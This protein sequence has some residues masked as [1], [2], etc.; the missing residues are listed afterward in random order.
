MKKLITSLCAFALTFSVANAQDYTPKAG[1]WS[2]ST[3]ASS[4]LTYV[5]NLFNGTA[6]APT[7]DFTNE[8]TEDKYA[9][10][11]KM[12]IDDNTAWRGQLNIGMTSSNP[13]TTDAASSSFD[14]VLGLGKE[15]RRGGDRLQGYYG[16]QAMMMLNSASEDD[17]NGDEISS[18][19]MFGFG[20][21]GFIGVEYF[22]KPKMSLGAEYTHGLSF[23]SGDDAS[24]FDISGAS[25]AIRMNFYF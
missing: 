18:E 9:V 11:G 2:I 15:F 3:D 22:V 23:M 1:D 17:A 13:D 14:L 10:V 25:T 6:D 20:A 8:V 16:Y 5:G 19:S 4:V 7:T 24:E 21:H 12:F